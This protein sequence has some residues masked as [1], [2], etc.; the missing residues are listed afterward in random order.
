MNERSFLKIPDEVLFLERG[1]DELLLTHA[2]IRKPLY[3]R[4]G[5]SYIQGFLS[6]VRELGSR[7]RVLKT[8][9]REVNLLQVLSDHWIVVDPT[10]EA[11]TQPAME[12]SSAPTTAPRPQM[13]LY[14]LLSQS[15]NMGCFYC[16]DGHR[17]YQR[18]KNIKMSREVA[19][20]TV[21]RCLEELSPA[22]LLEIVFFGGEPLLNWPL[23][24]EV[25][26]HC[27]KR[28]GEDHR[29]KM[30]KYHLTTNLSFL[31]DDLIDW[32]KKYEISF[33]CDVD[34]PPEI[35]DRCRP[36]KSGGGSHGAVTRNIRRLA[37]AGLKV[38]LRATVTALNQDHLAEVSAHHKEIGGSS[39]GF[40]PVIPIN[41]D[42]NILPEEMLPDP[43]KVIQR[44]AEVYQSKLWKPGELFP[45][46]Q[47]SDRFK[48]GCACAVGCGA[49]TGS[50]PAVDAKGDV[51]PCIYLVGIARYHMGN[52]L[53]GSYP[54]QP[55]IDRLYGE[56]RVD[57]MEDCKDCN[58]RTL[59]GG[60]C[61]LGRLTSLE[62]P[63][64]SPRVRDYIKKMRCDYTRNVLGELLWQKADESTSGDT[65]ERVPAGKCI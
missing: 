18:D 3:I 6:A 25:I 44:I 48:P 8:Y 64:T 17:T 12:W 7:E 37:E 19:I 33:L 63:E 2:N 59:C 57:R 26:L 5:R 56:L 42:E 15:C 45:F 10:M 21:D 13:T 30:R 20:R 65:Q 34:G 16:L 24:Q 51:Y 14:L 47:Y 11:R 41:S 58:W 53:D 43:E 38:D 49:A 27:E 55:V 22:G 9:P 61:P 31:P 36:L 50:A 4:E 60:G 29:D 35:H 52:M 40:V 46:N 54:R 62:N 28:L 39:S 32:A 1:Q 23:A